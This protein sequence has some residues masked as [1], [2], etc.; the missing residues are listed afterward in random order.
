MDAKARESIFVGYNRQKRGYRLVDSQTQRAFYSQTVVF[1][2][3]KTGR[4]SAAASS[5]ER[6]TPTRTST[7]PIHQYLDMDKATGENVP[8]MLEAIHEDDSSDE[9]GESGGTNENLDG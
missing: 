2:E 5:S 6:S 8:A 7:V 1:Y 9:G 4:L 3:S